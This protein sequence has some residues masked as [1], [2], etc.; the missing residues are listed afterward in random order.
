[1]KYQATIESKFIDDTISVEVPRNELI[2]NW[3]IELDEYADFLNYVRDSTIREFLYF[4]IQNL[5]KAEKFI[6]YKNQYLDVDCGEWVDTD[7]VEKEI[8][9]EY[10]PLNF[11]R[12]INR[13]DKEID[14]LL[15]VFNTDKK[16][17]NLYFQYDGFDAIYEYTDNE[18][19]LKE[20]VVPDQSIIAVMPVGIPGAGK[21]TLYQNEFSENFE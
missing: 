17:Q 16:L 4:N 7:P 21:S 20:G 12:K 14:S 19:I 10:F 18:L 1:L 13:K 5:K 6:H 3:K 9:R 8:N 15:S 2:K 11:K